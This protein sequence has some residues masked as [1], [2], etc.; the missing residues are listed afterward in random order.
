MNIGVGAVGLRALGLMGMV[1]ANDTG[2]NR[3]SAEGLAKTMIIVVT[4][5][6]AAGL[7][8]V[9]TFIVPGEG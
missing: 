3:K 1:Y 5:F 2:M 4:V 6:D 8:I 7:A 9:P